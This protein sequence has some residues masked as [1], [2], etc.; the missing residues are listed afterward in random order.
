MT[1]MAKKDDL[2]GTYTSSESSEA[3]SMKVEGG[4]GER[5]EW[6]VEMPKKENPHDVGEYYSP[7]DA[8]PP[9]RKD[10]KKKEEEEEE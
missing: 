5:R 6:T 7:F 9:L 8:L 10:K 3:W 2:T 1:S 4:S